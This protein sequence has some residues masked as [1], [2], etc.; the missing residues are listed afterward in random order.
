MIIF[1]G[2][3]VRLNG[4]ARWLEVVGIVDDMHIQLSNGGYLEASERFI[5]QVLSASE[6]EG[7]RIEEN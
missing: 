3:F 7:M 5:S 4:Q 2:D 1:E 6:M